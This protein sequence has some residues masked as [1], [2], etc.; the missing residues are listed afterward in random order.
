MVQNHSTDELI[1][2]LVG[3][4][5]G[6]NDQITT[7]PSSTVDCFKNVD[8]LLFVLHFLV[9][10]VV[11]T[12]TKIN[13]DMFVPEEEHDSRWVESSNIVLKSGTPVM[14][15]KYMTTKFL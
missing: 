14:S 12:S 2:V 5:F 10:L 6:S 8:E 3:V 1:M 9:D 7:L 11:F 13:H 4:I 15:T